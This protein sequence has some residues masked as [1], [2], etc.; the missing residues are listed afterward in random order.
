MQRCI[1]KALKRFVGPACPSRHKKISN[2]GVASGY[3][4]TAPAGHV[5]NQDETDSKKCL[6]GTY[7]PTIKM[8]YRYDEGPDDKNLT[9]Y[10]TTYIKACVNWQVNAEFIHTFVHVTS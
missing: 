1:R 8:N 9:F 4:C 5:T 10:S 6:S 2:A 3:V 7:D